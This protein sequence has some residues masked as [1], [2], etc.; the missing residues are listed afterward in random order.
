MLLT[1][2]PHMSSHLPPSGLSWTDLMTL[3]LD[4]KTLFLE[5]LKTPRTTQLQVKCIFV[6][7]LVNYNKE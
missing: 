2:E 1:C 4:L 6:K 3:T 5:I 7:G